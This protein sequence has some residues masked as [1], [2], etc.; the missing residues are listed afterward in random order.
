MNGSKVRRWKSNV[1]SF[2][3]T[4]YTS[5][6]KILRYLKFYGNLELITDLDETFLFEE[7]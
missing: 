2:E 3:N 5:I 4:V 7:K 6:L 1:F